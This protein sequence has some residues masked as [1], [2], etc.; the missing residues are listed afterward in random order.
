MHIFCDLGICFTKLSGV[1]EAGGHKSVRKDSDFH[2]VRDWR[3]VRAQA[4]SPSYE[5]Q[6]S[7]PLFTVFVAFGNVF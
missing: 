2:G 3:V 5:V 1:L 6:I 7:A 4:L